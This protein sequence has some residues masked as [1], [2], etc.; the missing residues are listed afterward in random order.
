NNI[1]S[2]NTDDQNNDFDNSNNADA[3]E[4]NNVEEEDLDYKADNEI[5]NKDSG[6]ETKLQMGF[7]END[8]YKYLQGW[9]I[10]AILQ[11]M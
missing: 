9:I 6:S 2:F 5:M 10:H 1:E 8:F 11:L 4:M 7:L 3:E